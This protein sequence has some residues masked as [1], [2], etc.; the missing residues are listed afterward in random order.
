MLENE[1]SLNKEIHKWEDDP[2]ATKII[3]L[4]EDNKVKLY[5]TKQHTKDKDSNCCYHQQDILVVELKDKNLTITHHPH[6]DPYVS[7]EKNL[8]YLM[9]GFYLSKSINFL[10]E[11]PMHF[12]FNYII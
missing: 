2:L 4:F 9:S 6:L 8:T 12:N 5:Y 1:Y 3:P 11:L 10:H 7:I